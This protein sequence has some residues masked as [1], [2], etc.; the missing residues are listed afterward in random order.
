MNEN[1][2]I[3]MPEKKMFACSPTRM[4]AIKDSFCIA[5][6]PISEDGAVVHVACVHQTLSRIFEQQIAFSILL[7]LKELEF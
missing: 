6:K 2:F 3:L 7:R 5:T 4:C 1:A